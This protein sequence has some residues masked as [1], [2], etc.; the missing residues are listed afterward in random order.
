MR[1]TLASRNGTPYYVG[2]SVKRLTGVSRDGSHRGYSVLKTEDRILI[3]E[4]PIR[5]TDAS[6]LKMFL[7]VLLWTDRFKRG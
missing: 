3:Q 6:L 2:Q 1:L 4:W 5:S 7:I